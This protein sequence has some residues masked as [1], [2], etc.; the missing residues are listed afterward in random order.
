M[1]VAEEGIIYLH[2]YASKVVVLH[3]EDLKHQVQGN[4]TFANAFSL[5]DEV[6]MQ[7][8]RKTIQEYAQTTT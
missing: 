5:V 3:N 7:E 6:V 4:L 8:V 1:V 2:K